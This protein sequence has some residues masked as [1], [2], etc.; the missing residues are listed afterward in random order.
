MTAKEVMNTEEAAEFLGLAP[1]TIRKY[2]RKGIIPGKKVGGK[3]WRFV[4]ADLLA[5]LREQIPLKAEA[6]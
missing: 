2:A 3:E 1:F 4:K 6:D 5:W